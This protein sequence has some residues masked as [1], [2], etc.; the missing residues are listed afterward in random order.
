MKCKKM[1]G[2]QNQRI[3]YSPTGQQARE[4]HFCR[5]ILAQFIVQYLYHYSKTN[6]RNASGAAS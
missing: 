3:S 2:D 1:S 6:I 5:S 4:Q